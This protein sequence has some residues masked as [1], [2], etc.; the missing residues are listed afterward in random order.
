MKKEGPIWHDTCGG[1][2]I[3]SKREA[4]RVKAGIGRGRRKDLRIY[5]CP[6]CH[7]YHL[8]KKHRAPSEKSYNRKHDDY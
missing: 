1:K 2:N 7:G 5:E 8:T 4:E 3:Y 6:N